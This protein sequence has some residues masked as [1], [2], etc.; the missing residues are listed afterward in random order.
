MRRVTAHAEDVAPLP[1]RRDAPAR[2]AEASPRVL[3]V[4]PGI[5]SRG[6]IVSVVRLHMTMP[7]W[8][9][10][11]CDLLATYDDRSPA[12]KVKSALLAYLRAPVKVMR[13][14]IVHLHVA[15]ELSLLRKLP[16]FAFARCCRKAVIVHVH[17][18]SPES[19]FERTPAWAVQFVLGKADRVLALS[20]SWASL[21][22]DR[23]QGAN[24]SV[25]PNPVADYAADAHREPRRPMVLFVGRLEPRKGY[26]TLLQAAALILKR[27]PE[28]EFWFAGHGELNRATAEARRLGI[29]ASVHLCGWTDPEQTA[30]LYEQASVFCLPSHNE[31][32]PMSVLE[33]MSHGTPVVCTRVGGL[34]EF[35]VEGETGSFAEVGDPQSTA[36]K[37]LRFLEDP[38]FAATVAA[39]ARRSVQHRCSLAAVEGELR[40]I[41]AGL[42]RERATGRVAEPTASL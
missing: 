40:K 11:Q 7:L 3:V 17:A 16:I 22:R 33:A 38:A 19:L 4:A 2:T 12:A 36:D 35:V 32:V 13:A 23:I 26:T 9:Q 41:Y 34:S 8:G 21:I 39:A 31:G 15:G 18:S 1:M 29:E 37:I 25:L 10:M 27:H 28:T 6:G 42:L 24:I 20:Q 30:R 14:D 5:N